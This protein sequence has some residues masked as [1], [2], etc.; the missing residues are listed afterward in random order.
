M[1]PF[2][3]PLG[4]AGTSPGSRPL[5]R[6]SRSLSSPSVHTPLV[7]AAEEHD[8]GDFGHESLAGSASSDVPQPLDNVTALSASSGLEGATEVQALSSSAFIPSV[9]DVLEQ[10]FPKESNKRL[11]IDLPLYYYCSEF[12]NYS[13]L[14]ISLPTSPETSTDMSTK[15][16][17][18][19]TLPS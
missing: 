4:T 17:N 5:P 8:S 10:M 11:L 6:L 1:K 14:N 12:L 19:T 13:Q 9:I 7:S 15:G 16:H 3:S 2:L 18:S